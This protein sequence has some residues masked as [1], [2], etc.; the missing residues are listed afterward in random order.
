MVLLLASAINCMALDAPVAVLLMVRALPPVL[1]PSKVTLSAPLKKINGPFIFPSIVCGP[2]LGLMDRDAQSPASRIA[3][4]GS[5]TLQAISMAIL[6]EARL[7]ASC[8]LRSV[9]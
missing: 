4:L 3:V 6:M 7:R 1:R 2:P 5:V 8:L 9:S